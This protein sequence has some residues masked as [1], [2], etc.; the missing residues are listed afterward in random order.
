MI[1]IE[2][3]RFA[4]AVEQILK[5]ELQKG[6]LPSSKE[7]GLRLTQYLQSQNLGRPE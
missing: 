7:F 4:A 1:G 5:E 6:N 2:Q 3:K